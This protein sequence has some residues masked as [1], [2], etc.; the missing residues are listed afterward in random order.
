[1]WMVEASFKDRGAD[2]ASN[3]TPSMNPKDI[4]L[5]E[6]VKCPKCRS[7]KGC[8]EFEK[9][10]HGNLT[11]NRVI[12]YQEIQFPGMDVVFYV[13]PYTLPVYPHPASEPFPF[14]MDPPFPHQRPPCPFW[15]VRPW[16]ACLNHLS[17]MSQDISHQPQWL[18]H[19]LEQTSLQELLVFELHHMY[20]GTI[21][22]VFWHQ[23]WWN[24][25]C[26]SLVNAKE[27]W[28]M[29]YIIFHFLAVQSY[30]LLCISY[31]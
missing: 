16:R 2:A 11:S 28:L 12:L 25:Y 23:R 1:M 10:E 14:L 31:T 15:K 5:E 26:T 4:W 3:I 20:S 24:L 9:I 29:N 8:W 21:F 6:V 17:R 13:Y 30:G 22:N 19:T 18:P 7:C 27:A